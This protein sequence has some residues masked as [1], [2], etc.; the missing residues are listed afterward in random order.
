MVNLHLGILR[1]INKSIDTLFQNHFFFAVLKHVVTKVLIFWTLQRPV[2]GMVWVE[3]ERCLLWLVTGA[4]PIQYFWQ[5]SPIFSQDQL[6]IRFD[7]LL[8]FLP[9]S[10][11]PLNI[12]LA[13]ASLLPCGCTGR[14]C[15]AR[16]GWWGVVSVTILCPPS[17]QSWAQ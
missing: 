13:T 2:G 6:I 14:A 15:W 3:R 12:V 4:S 9:S 8:S 17:S 7:P 5:K 10:L 1:R 11:R 16:R